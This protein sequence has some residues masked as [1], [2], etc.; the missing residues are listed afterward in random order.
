MTHKNH[1]PSPTHPPKNENIEEKKKKTTFSHS[2]V[3]SL[4]KTKKKKKTM[5]FNYSYTKIF[6]VHSFSP[7]SLLPF[8]FQ[9][10]Q[11]W[12][13]F[14]GFHSCLIIKLKNLDY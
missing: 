4:E 9:F 10:G 6:K 5:L 7:S 2:P 12:F 8:F 3:G 13:G 11:N 1:V 14:L